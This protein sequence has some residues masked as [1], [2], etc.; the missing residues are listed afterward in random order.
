M[1]PYREAAPPAARKLT[2]WERWFTKECA[3][4]GCT[5]RVSRLGVRWG[6]AEIF[7]LCT[8]CV[9]LAVT[10]S[11]RHATEQGR[12]GD[13]EWAKRVFPTM[14]YRRAIGKELP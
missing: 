11:L 14:L 12:D 4:P 9:T 10:D 1:N 2:L 7:G 5:E 3:A 8:A 6:A 13:D